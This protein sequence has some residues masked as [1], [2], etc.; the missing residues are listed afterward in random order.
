MLVCMGISGKQALGSRPAAIELP[1]AF[2]AGDM[3]GSVS[4]ELAK[5]GNKRCC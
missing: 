5:T 4:H 1:D 2:A 3:Y